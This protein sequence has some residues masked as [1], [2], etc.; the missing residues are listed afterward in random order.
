[1]QQRQGRWSG[2]DG[3]GR[4]MEGVRLAGIGGRCGVGAGFG[5]DKPRGLDGRGALF[6]KILRGEA[7]ICQFFF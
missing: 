3:V 6:S 4:R 2:G 1:M 7:V 5:R